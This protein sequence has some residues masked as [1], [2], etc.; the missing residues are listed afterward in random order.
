MGFEKFKVEGK[1][2]SLSD[3]FRRLAENENR[4]GA[5]KDLSLGE[6][7]GRK[8][9]VLVRFRSH[10]RTISLLPIKDLSFPEDDLRK[11]SPIFGR[12]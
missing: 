5:V 10:P 11:G 6:L 12:R 9:E 7:K 4:S 8:V 2:Y 1:R 3:I